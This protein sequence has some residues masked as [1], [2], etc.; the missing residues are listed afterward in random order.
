MALYLGYKLSEATL[1]S[2]SSFLVVPW[3]VGLVVGDRWSGRLG[4]SDYL[5]KYSHSGLLLHR[6]SM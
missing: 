3:S 6:Q 5:D 2:C 4:G 1:V